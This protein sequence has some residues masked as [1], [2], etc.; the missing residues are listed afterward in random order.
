[1]GGLDAARI[2]T[3]CKSVV[4]IILIVVADFAARVFRNI[5]LG[6]GIAAGCLTIMIAIRSA[7]IMSVVTG[8]GTAFFRFACVVVAVDKIVAVVVYAVVTDFVGFEIRENAVVVKDGACRRTGYV[9]AGVERIPV[10][11][12]RPA[13][14]EVVLITV[15]AEIGHT[16][17]TIFDVAIGI[18][19]IA[20]R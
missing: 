19:D 13:V 9:S 7:T 2:G 4:V 8:G 14:A 1:M 11:A 20:C 5:R 18:I 16:V 17:A 15:L 3:V 10:G 6:T 12:E